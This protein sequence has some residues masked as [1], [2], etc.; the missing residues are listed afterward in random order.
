MTDREATNE[1]L[2][3][4]ISEGFETWLHEANA[5][6]VFALPPAK[7]MFVG[8]DDA[9]GIAVFERTFDKAMG[10]AHDPVRDAIHVGTRREI[11]RLQNVLSPGERTETG[12]DRLYVPME[13]S[14][15]GYV[16][17]HDLGVE[18]DGRVLMVN[19]RFGCLARVSPTHSFQPVWWPPFLP[20]PAPNDRCHLNGLAMRGGRADAVTT[21]STS[22]E[23]DGWRADRRDGGTIIDVAS[24]EIIARR[25][26]MP[27]SPRWHD[28][29]LWVANA[30]TGE[31]GH[32]DLE[33]GRFEPVAALPGFARGLCFVG[34]YAVVGTSKPRHGDIYSGLA[35][36][37][38]LASRGWPPRLGI[39]VVDLNSG[40]V[41]EWLQVDGVARELFEVMALPG[42]RRPAALGL[43]SD[44]IATQFR[45]SEVP[46]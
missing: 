5:S 21:V 44:E 3:L 27:H 37:D 30:G 12:H 32:I 43:R 22:A 41:V 39:F 31:L 14:T 8:L 28:D 17:V 33:R 46:S 35:L 11:W 36:E 4:R 13:R 19:T 23:V 16:N 1:E 24:G 20:G 7:L 45:F 6:L 9:G 29:K 10:I 15:T 40:E 34:N 25:L 26:S 38:R 2:P 42:V 18:R